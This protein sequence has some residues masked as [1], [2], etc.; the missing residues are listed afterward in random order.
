MSKDFGVISV[1][2]LSD[3]ERAVVRY[4]FLRT[5]NDI[6]NLCDLPTNVIEKLSVLRMLKKFESIEGVGSRLLNNSYLIN[7]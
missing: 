4:N 7:I 3:G 1:S 2:I 6:V 5:G